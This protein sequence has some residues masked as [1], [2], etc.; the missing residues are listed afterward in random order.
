M[1]ASRRPADRDVRDPRG[2]VSPPLEA[3]R[4][5]PVAQ[6]AT[7]HFH[8][9]AA[10]CA[11]LIFDFILMTATMII[12]DHYY[13]YYYFPRERACSRRCFC[14]GWCRISLRFPDNTVITVPRR[15]NAMLLHKYTLFYVFIVF[16]PPRD[17]K[18]V[19]IDPAP[20]ATPIHRRS[21]KRKWFCTT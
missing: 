15:P 13:Y 6:P 19:S 4:A 3:T 21:P 17:P 7:R 1:H 5:S 2:I 9:T 16:L 10:A 11:F 18:R 12:A 14:T 8:R 20:A